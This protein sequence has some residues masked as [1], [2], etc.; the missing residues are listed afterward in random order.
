MSAEALAAWLLVRRNQAVH[1]KSLQEDA[2]CLPLG[3]SKLKKGNSTIISTRQVFLL[4]TAYHISNIYTYVPVQSM[5]HTYLSMIV[6]LHNNSISNPYELPPPSSVRRVNIEWDQPVRLASRAHHQSRDTFRC[7]T[8]II[9]YIH[10]TTTTAAVNSIC[11][12]SSSRKMP[13]FFRVRVSQHV[14]F[15]IKRRAS[16]QASPYTTVPPRTATTDLPASSVH[17]TLICAWYLYEYDLIPV[18]SCD[19]RWQYYGGR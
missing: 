17:S 13:S 10:S 4:L 16:Q 5:Y 2:S 3:D 11:L 8:T 14:S 15:G 19:L 7:S 6:F 1:T 12:Y 9:L 18:S